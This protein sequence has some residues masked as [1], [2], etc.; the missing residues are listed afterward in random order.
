VKK[1]LSIMLVISIASLVCGS[2]V[3]CSSSTTSTT[4]AAGPLQQKTILIGIDTPLTGPAAP[5][6]L[7][8]EH[9]V[10]LAFDDAN[11]AGGVTV[12]N[13]HYTFKCIA[14]DDQ[15]D[16]ATATNN[17]RQL[18]FQDGAQYIFTFQTEGTLAVNAEL[19]QQ[20]VIDFTV[21][22]DNSVI[23]QPTDDY[24]F[25]AFVSYPE[26]ATAYFQWII[27]Q[28]P[29]AKRMVLITT[30]NT[31][32][33]IVQAAT[34]ASCQAAGLTYVD[35]VLYDA[36][37]TDFTPFLTKL[38]AEKPDMINMT[39]APSGDDAVMINTARSMG[40]TGLFVLS[41]NAAS[42]LLPITGAA[43]IE[44][45]LDTNLPPQAPFVSSITLALPG[46]EVAKWGAS[47]GVTWDFY[48]QA[49]IM[50]TAMKRADSVDTTAVKNILQDP[51]QT[52]PYAAITG[53]VA[54]FDTPEAVALVG[55]ADA[56]NQILTP[57][58]IDIIHNGQDVIQT[59]IEPPGSTTSTTP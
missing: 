18:V 37:T 1:L 35:S 39:G 4:S 6:G 47:Y 3:G 41:N 32:G 59:I 45:V 22:L 7:G 24:T 31:N 5:Y 57:W 19:S 53:G 49:T 8:Q 30:N 55:A 56:T 12:G 14:L 51:T 28:Y 34:Q 48:S 54:K 25:R 27:Q 40:Y 29:T 2:L 52:W 23:T 43:N 15:Y 10:E 50:Y 36:G 42:D 26:Q 11:A 21:V 44:G 9:G 38:L 58:A 17:I 13:T 16:T 46:R 20:K 33:E